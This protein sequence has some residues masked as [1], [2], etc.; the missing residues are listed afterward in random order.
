MMPLQFIQSLLRRLGVRGL[1]IL[2]AL[3]WTI[4]L[5]LTVAMASFVPEVAFVSTVSP[6]SWLSRSCGEG[7]TG[8]LVRLPMDIPGET[9]CLPYQML[10]RSSL[11]FFVPTM[12]AT[13]V[14]SASAC[15]V[16]SLALW[17]APTRDQHY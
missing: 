1:L 2:H 5:S 6:S 14:V 15:F 11:D 7:T 12:V 17:D 10:R 16:R 9:V 8:T 3:I 13:L 4:L